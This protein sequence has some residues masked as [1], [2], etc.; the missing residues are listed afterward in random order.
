MPENLAVTEGSDHGLSVGQAVEVARGALAGVRG[1]LVGFSHTQQCR[2][3]LDVAQR[4]VLLVIGPEA[5][6]QLS[7]AADN[8]PLV[9]ADAMKGSNSNFFRST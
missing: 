1:V 3:E 2:I 6:K 4:G 5:V 7:L 9:Q 8:A